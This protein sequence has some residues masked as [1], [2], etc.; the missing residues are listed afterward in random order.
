MAKVP[1]SFCQKHFG[2]IT[3]KI[4]GRHQSRT[5]GNVELRETIEDARKNVMKSSLITE[6]LLNLPC[7]AS[8]KAL[9][10]P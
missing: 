8:M 7:H 4:S 6:M 10:V 9:K 1:V 2:K 5:S 3:K